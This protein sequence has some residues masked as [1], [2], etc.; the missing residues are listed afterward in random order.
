[1]T[2][3]SPAPRPNMRKPPMGGNNGARTS[4]RQP[5]FNEDVPV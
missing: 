2:K 1:M 3:N 4:V 5:E